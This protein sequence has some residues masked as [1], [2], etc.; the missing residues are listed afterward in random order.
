MQN[1]LLLGA[2]K[3]AI[4]FI[5]YIVE[6]AALSDW[7]LTVA[8]LTEELA[9]A[10]TKNRPNT[11]A[12][13]ISIHNKENRQK[14]ISEADIVVSMLPASFHPLIAEDCLLLKKNLVTPSYVSEAMKA[15]EPEV[16]AT[17]LLF[18]NE[19]G[20]DPGIDHLSSMQIIHSLKSNGAT[21]IGY[22]SHCGGLIAPKSGNNLWHYK[23]TWNPRNVIVAG[24]GDGGIRYLKDG[25]VVE[26]QYDQLFAAAQ[27]MEVEGYGYFESY[28]NRDSLKYIEQYD[29]KEVKTMY[30]GTLRVPPF[31]AGWNFLVGLGLT[32]DKTALENLN[33]TTYA[34]FFEQKRNGKIIPELVQPLWATLLS[35]DIIPLQQATAAQVLQSLLEMQWQMQPTDSDMIVMVHQVD[36]DL[37]G[38]NYR[39]QSALVYE[40][41]DGEHTAMAKTVGFPIAMAVKRILNKEINLTGVQLPVAPI[42]YNPILAELKEYGITFRETIKQN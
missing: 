6:R 28:P 27:Q 22:Q 37:E 10:K 26:L 21:I 19:M 30:R 12:V 32:E 33:S 41:E 9:L 24:Q 11:K 36:Y 8:D 40:G 39:L 13:S 23:F 7:L 14:L 3:S 2:G 5:D 31:C 25:S 38:K 35:N 20:L 17:G 16:K 42:I 1:I 4:A 29:L 15:M 34:Q 18:L